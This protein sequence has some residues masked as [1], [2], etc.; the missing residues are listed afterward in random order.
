MYLSIK[1]VA[2]CGVVPEKFTAQAATMM[3]NAAV[4]AFNSSW[5]DYTDKKPLLPM[6]LGFLGNYKTGEPE[7]RSR[8]AIPSEHDWRRFTERGDACRVV[9][10]AAIELDNDDDEQDLIRYDNLIDMSEKIRDSCSIYS[11]G[12]NWKKEW[13]FN[14]S[15][16]EARTEEIETWKKEKERI[17]INKY[18]ACHED[19]KTQI[20]QKIKELTE[21]TNSFVTDDEYVRTKQK[22]EKLTE[23]IKEKNHDLRQLGVFKGSKKKELKR[24]VYD[25]IAEKQQLVDEVKPKEDAIAE[26]QNELEHLKAKLENP[27]E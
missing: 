23:Q 26:K 20:E 11:D 9:L 6:K 12:G 3:D 22:I 8:Y 25:L 15:A 13:C 2:S 7:D 17:Q 5:D 14:N 4:A 24:Q 16:K 18:W 27:L 21:E 10:K 19:E 1:L